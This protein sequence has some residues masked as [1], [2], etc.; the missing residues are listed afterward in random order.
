MQEIRIVLKK[1]WYEQ[2]SALVVPRE[3]VQKQKVTYSNWGAGV[4]RHIT[5]A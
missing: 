4:M 5:T 2:M 1:L 3:S